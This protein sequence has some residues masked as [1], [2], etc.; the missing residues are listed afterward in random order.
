MTIRHLDSLFRPAAVVVVG[1][2]RRDASPGGI[3]LR[4]LRAGGFAG[5]VLAVNR[6]AAMVQGQ[7][8][9]ADVDSL[10]LVPD[11][12]VI[13]APAL[14]DIPGI[15]ASLGR[16]GC[17]GFIVLSGEDDAAAIAGSV[18]DAMLTAARPWLGRV[19]GPDCFGLMVPALGLNATLAQPMPRP[20]GIACVTRSG[21]VAA[22]M[23]DWAATT[24][25]GISKLVGAGTAADVDLADLLDYLA[26]DSATEVIAL[27]LDGVANGRKFLSAARAA[28]RMKPLVVCRAGRAGDADPRTDAIYDAVLRRAGALRVEGLDDLFDAAVMMARRHRRV[29]SRLGIVCNGAGLGA[30]AAD[31]AITAGLHPGDTVVLDD[32][33]VPA[34]YAAAVSAMAQQPDIDTMLLSHAPSPLVGISDVV[35]AVAQAVGSDPPA[36][37][38]CFPGTGPAERDRLAAAG[39][40]L[41]PSPGRAVRG[42]AALLHHLGLQ[43]QAQRVP[44]HRGGDAGLPLDRLRAGI[45]QAAAQGDNDLSPVIALALLAAHGIQDLP[46]GIA[47]GVTCDAVFGPVV[48]CDSAA[49]PRRFGIPP[50]DP[51]LAGDMVPA[52]HAGTS[53]LAGILTALGRLAIDHPEIRDLTVDDAPGGLRCRATLQPCRAAIRPA[54]RPYPDELASTCRVR[55]GEM[56]ALR[57]VRPD[58]A[59]MVDDLFEHLTPDDVH[60]RF[61]SSLRT[62]PRPLRARLTQIDYDREMALVALA[63]QDGET[64]LIGMVHLLADPDFDRA[65]FAVMVRSDWQGHGVGYALMGAILAYARSRGLRRVM[66]LVLNENGRMLAMARQFGFTVRHG[67]EAG[68]SEVHL[69]L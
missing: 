54:I 7:P 41:Y 49:G 12:A 1:A 69:D 17:R 9:Y 35:A 51:E 62:L 13:A 44:S 38:A 59:G 34:R 58:D 14:R 29:G 5:P 60:T 16:R 36:L 40:C 20:G 55:D 66:G 32:H 8:A 21:A 47:A 61:F 56:I 4:R 43:R 33:A 15:V 39:F 18:Q 25:F 11:L 23:L 2:S 48:W 65:E 64:R 26:L 68:T 19:L 42:L 50:L 3:A 31:A 45:A 57:P 37:A 24:G 30:I 63:G 67:P 10:P 46:T 53:R 27:H 28:A 6:R 52:A 22:T